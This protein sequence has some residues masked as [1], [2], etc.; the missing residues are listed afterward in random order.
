VLAANTQLYWNRGRGCLV[1]RA[2]G[3][4]QTGHQAGSVVR[5]RACPLLDGWGSRSGGPPFDRRWPKS[6]RGLI[7]LAGAGARNG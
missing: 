7:A 5:R 2:R 1:H 4:D 3:K 6:V